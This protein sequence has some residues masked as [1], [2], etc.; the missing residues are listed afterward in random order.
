MQYVSVRLVLCFGGTKKERKRK[1]RKKKRGRS[2]LF[3]FLFVPLINYEMEAAICEPE[4]AERFQ[5]AQ[6]HR[7]RD[8]FVDRVSESP[9]E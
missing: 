1:R 7:E 2:C 3:V 4:V 5:P 6:R 9:V 8:V